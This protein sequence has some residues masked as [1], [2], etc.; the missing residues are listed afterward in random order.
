MVESM[1]GL[2]PVL[3]VEVLAVISGDLTAFGTPDRLSRIAGPDRN[4]LSRVG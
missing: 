3:G 2:S 4:H 1:A